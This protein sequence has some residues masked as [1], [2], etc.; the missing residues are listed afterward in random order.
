[1]LTAHGHDGVFELSIALEL[2]STVGKDS[3]VRVVTLHLVFLRQII[4]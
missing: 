2:A 4:L 3:S 1:V